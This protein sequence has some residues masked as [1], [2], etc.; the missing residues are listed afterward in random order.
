MAPFLYEPIV[1][2]SQS[3]SK[4]TER[5]YIAVWVPTHP[6][7]FCGGWVF[8]HRLVMELAKGR[9][10]HCSETVHHINEQKDDNRL[11]NLFVCSEAEHMKAHCQSLVAC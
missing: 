5:G 3:D 11:D 1:N 4:A 9:V 7:A 6:K 2:W 10:L 8:E